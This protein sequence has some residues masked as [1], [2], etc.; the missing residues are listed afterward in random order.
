MAV[1]ID[2][3]GWIG[4][5]DLLIAYALLT[6]GRLRADSRIYQLMN[7]AGALCLAANASYHGAVPVAILNVAWFVIGVFGYARARKRRSAQP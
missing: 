7:F 6:L 4:M 1:F 2:V 5:V 3:I